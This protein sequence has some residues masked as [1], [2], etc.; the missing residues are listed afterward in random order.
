MNKGVRFNFHSFFFLTLQNLKSVE[1]KCN[2][3]IYKVRSIFNTL[4]CEIICVIPRVNNES[5]FESILKEGKVIKEIKDYETLLGSITI[6][7]IGSS[8]K[9]ELI[10]NYIDKNNIERTSLY[11]IINSLLKLRDYLDEKS[12]VT[13]ISIP[14]INN[15]LV[16]D[17][18]DIL[19][20]NTDILIKYYD[21][22]IN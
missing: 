22:E 3:K 19:F 4:D 2:M 8:L 21:Y 13:S 1:I 7:K 6:R 9:A 17:I 15:I 18:I 16:D 20:K 14:N 10:S 11:G 5:I 12:D